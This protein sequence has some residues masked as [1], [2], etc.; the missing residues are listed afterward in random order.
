MRRKFIISFD[1]VITLILVFIIIISSISYSF[2]FIVIPA[3]NNILYTFRSG[4]NSSKTDNFKHLSTTEYKLTNSS[5]LQQKLSSY[6]SINNETSGLNLVRGLNVAVGPNGLVYAIGDESNDSVLLVMNSTG[7]ILSIKHFYGLNDS[8]KS[9][10]IDPMGYIYLTGTTEAYNLKTIRAFQSSNAGNF[11]CF[12]IKFNASF[13]AVFSTYLGG[14]NY[15]IG[16]SIAVDS[17]GNSYVVGST[18]SSNF[19]IYNPFQGNY[20]GNT[21]GFLAKFNPTGTLLYST[22]IGGTNFDSATGV[23]ADNS[24]NAYVTGMTDSYY[25]P[26]VKAFQPNLAGLSDAFIDKFNSVGGMVFGSFLGGERNDYSNGIT[27]DSSGNNIFITGDT[28]SDTFANKNAYQSNN[29]GGIDI[30]VTKISTNGNLVFSTYLGGSAIDSNSNCSSSIAIDNVSNI[31]VTGYTYSNDFPTKNAF[32]SKLAGRNDIILASFNS[33]GSLLYSTY[34]GGNKSEMITTN[35]PSIT[36]DPSGNT[37]ITGETDSSNFPTKNAYQ[38]NF[39]GSSDFFVTSFNRSRVLS[40]STF[41]NENTTNPT[42]SINTSSQAVNSSISITRPKPNQLN[43]ILIDILL[44]GFLVFISLTIFYG[45]SEYNKYSRTKRGS[46]RNYNFSFIHYLK[47]KYKA[48]FRKENAPN[49]LSERIFEILTEIE[50]ENAS[51]EN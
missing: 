26:V 9:M 47:N 45:V 11:D 44:F 13:D 4:Y 51:D 42:N 24:G 27:I 25:F 33:A 29:N 34:L 12:V 35:G 48:R 41:L 32:Q 38:S 10:A 43:P 46:R 50:E 20:G 7:S 2:A 8:I 31:Y 15:D 39:Y 19:P 28:Y 1:F 22:Y 5:G 17:F 23:I 30:F 3:K 37:F 40:F 6:L 36:V 21:D 49:T 14:N 16:N 18:A